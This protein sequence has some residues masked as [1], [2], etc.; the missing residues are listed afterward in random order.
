MK[1]VAIIAAL[2]CFVGVPSVHAGTISGLAGF[3]ESWNGQVLQWKKGSYTDQNVAGTG[4]A[5]IPFGLT[6]PAGYEAGG[7]QKYP[8]VLYLHGAGARGNNNNA[9]LTRQ[10]PRFFA[11]Q[12][13][14]TPQYN[15]FVLSTQVTSDKRYVDV[16]W[17]YGPYDQGAVTITE[18]MHL[19]EGLLKYLIDSGNNAVLAAV[20]GIRADTIDTTRI[21]VVGD[22]MGAYGT[23]DTVGRNPGLYA[24]AIAAAGSGPK[25]R[26]QELQ[27]TPFWAI[28]GQTDTAVPNSLPNDSDPDGAGSLGMLALIDP[29]FD[30]GLSTDLIKLDNYASSDDDPVA[31]NRFIYSQYPGE[32][33]H[34]TVAT[35]WTTRTSGISKWLFSQRLPEPSTLVLLI[36]GAAM[37]SSRPLR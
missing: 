7:T 9:N 14:T 19:T 3:S 33:S 2:I 35:E 5:S 22:S 8:L 27:K 4:S 12:A 31:W 26:L 30:N 1:R 34:A 18:P 23:W 36:A 16:D 21:Y 25:N 37:L 32:Y 13:L 15:A 20:L 28:H 11:H 10:T 6:L 17:N 24:A 29:G